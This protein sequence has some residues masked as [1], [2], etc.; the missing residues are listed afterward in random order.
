MTVL[1]LRVSKFANGVSKLH[2]EVSR[3]MWKDLFKTEVG[4]VPI[5]FITNGIHVES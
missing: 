4:N 3:E 2:A 5:D 1:A